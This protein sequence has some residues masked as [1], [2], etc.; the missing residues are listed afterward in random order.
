M[1]LGAGALGP[2]EARGRDAGTGG[3]R[4]GSGVRRAVII[5]GTG[6]IGRATAPPPGVPDTAATERASLRKSGSHR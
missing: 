5:G 6:A 4:Y 2:G 1:S 3:A